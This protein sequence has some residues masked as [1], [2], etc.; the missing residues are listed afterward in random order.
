V[1][2]IGFF[3]HVDIAWDDPH[4]ALLLRRLASFCRLV[5]FDRRGT[6]AS[7][8]LPPGP[9]PA[10]EAYAEELVA[11]M[12]ADCRGCE[13]ADP[14]QA[15]QCACLPRCSTWGSEAGGRPVSLATASDVV[16]QR[17]CRMDSNMVV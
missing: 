6:G 14:D 8:P 3:S 12:E 13:L 10:W 9:L 17:P 2:T 5:R 16:S 4:T 15:D 1:L 11:V 7:D